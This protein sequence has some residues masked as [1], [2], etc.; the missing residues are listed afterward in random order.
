MRILKRGVYQRDRCGIIVHA[1]LTA[2]QWKDASLKII[3][4]LNR[5]LAT[6]CPIH[7]HVRTCAQVKFYPAGHNDINA[8]HSVHLN[9]VKNTIKNLSKISSASPCQV[10]RNVW[11]ISQSGCFEQV[12]L[13]TYILTWHNSDKISA[14]IKDEDF[15]FC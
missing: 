11:E 7:R 13:G 15:I 8:F 6:N 12:W 14:N 4:K 10:K 1:C 2:P 9:D 5:R 3:T